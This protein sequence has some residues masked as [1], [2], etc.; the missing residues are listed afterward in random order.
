MSAWWADVSNR[1]EARKAGMQGVWAAAIIAV[2]TAIFAAVGPKLGVP[3]SFVDA[4]IFAAIAG[5]IAIMSRIAAVAGLALYV[6]ESLYKFS[7][8]GFKGVPLTIVLTIAFLNSVRGT[9]AFHSFDDMATPAPGQLRAARVQ[10]PASPSLVMTVA[11]A[12]GLL[13]AGIGAFFGLQWKFQRDAKGTAQL[14]TL[15]PVKMP[16]VP[17]VEQAIVMPQPKVAAQIGETKTDPASEMKKKQAEAARLAAEPQIYLE[18]EWSMY[19]VA[20]CKAV[21]PGMRQVPIEQRPI[22]YQPHMCVPEELKTWTR[23]LRD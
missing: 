18:P 3:A 15:P 8:I 21:K 19:H 17:P 5:G 1:E 23:K 20:G 16:D 7:T 2:I 11:V 12:I 6:V 4:V 13:V 10:Q 22:S 14:G 9:F